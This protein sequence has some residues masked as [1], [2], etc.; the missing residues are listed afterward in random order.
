M[1]AEPGQPTVNP[2]SCSAL[3]VGCP[4]GFEDRLLDKEHVLD[5][6]TTIA[7]AFAGQEPMTGHLGITHGEWLEFARRFCEK[8]VHEGLS[9]VTV[10]ITTGKVA[11]VCVSEDALAEQPDLSDL[12]EK[13][14]VVLEYLEQLGTGWDF[15]GAKPGKLFHIFLIATSPAYRKRGLGRALFAANARHGRS[16]GFDTAIVEATGLFSQRIAESLGF[17]TDTEIR[18]K[19]FVTASGEAA[20]ADY[21]MQHPSAKGMS[22]SLM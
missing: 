1:P 13:W 20:Y 2:V 8:A 14:S 17:R 19:D 4:A 9:H 12:S 3:D 21:T 15:E 16:R 5:A 6:A 22:L 7:D 10:D 11:C 18:Y